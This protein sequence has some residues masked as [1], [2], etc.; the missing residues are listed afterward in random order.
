MNSTPD[1]STASTQ[2]AALPPALQERLLAAMHQAVD[3]ERN[4]REVEQV[5]RRMQPAP[6]ST[7]L[8]GR[9][10][11]QMYVASQMRLYSRRS[12]AYW[13]RGSAVAAAAVALVMVGGSM[14]LPG[15]AVAQ[16]DNQGLVGRN[17]IDSRGMDRVVW[18]RGEAPVRHYEVIYEDSFVLETDD[19]TTVIRVP[20]R[21]EVEVEE[22]YL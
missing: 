14:L 12:Y 19:T 20:N 10:S 16:S 18:R 2:P 21:A 5:L 8:A 7:Q 1:I 15:S 22:E 6:L 17:I 11:G 9:V 3:E 4:C 13:W